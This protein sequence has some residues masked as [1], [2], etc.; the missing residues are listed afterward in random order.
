MIEKQKPSRFRKRPLL[1]A[2]AGVALISIGACGGYS[3]GNLVAPRCPDGG[4]DDGNDCKVV[5]DAGTADGGVKDGG[6]GG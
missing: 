4:F 1:V 6:D 2:A 5:A 3:S